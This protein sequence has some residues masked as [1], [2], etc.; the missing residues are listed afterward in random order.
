MQT[1]RLFR[2]L[3]VLRKY[4]LAMHKGRL[5]TNKRKLDLRIA[6]FGANFKGSTPGIIIHP[7]RYA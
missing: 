6:G 1:Y 7:D 5:E 2:I 3:G 4:Q